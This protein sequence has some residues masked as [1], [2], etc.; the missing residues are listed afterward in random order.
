MSAVGKKKRPVKPGID[1]KT[2]RRLQEASDE[3]HLGLMPLVQVQAALLEHEFARGR[4]SVVPGPDTVAG[5][6]EEVHQALSLALVESERKRFDL[7]FGPDGSPVG[8]GVELSEVVR[9]V[10]TIA[11]LFKIDIGNVMNVKYKFDVDQPFEK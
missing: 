8:F 10:L 6:L 5:L 1:K 4:I 2:I 3:Q 7:T 11:E 9:R